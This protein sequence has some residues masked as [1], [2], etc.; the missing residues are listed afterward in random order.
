MKE[1]LKNFAID[2]AINLVVSMYNKK[3]QE[4]TIKL[5][6]EISLKLD[7]KLDKSIK[8][9]NSTKIRMV[10]SEIIFKFS[11]EIRDPALR[12]DNSNK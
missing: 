7:Y 1:F 4:A 8:N 9:D 11:Q 2:T 6:R 12:R 5:F 10:L 3:G